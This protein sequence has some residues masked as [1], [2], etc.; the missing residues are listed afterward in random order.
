MTGFLLWGLQPVVAVRVTHQ[1][2]SVPLMTAPAAGSHGASHCCCSATAG[3]QTRRASRLIDQAA[4]ALTLEPQLQAAWRSQACRMPGVLSA[5]AARQSSNVAE[6]PVEAGTASNSTLLHNSSAALDSMHATDTDVLGAGATRD[7]GSGVGSQQAITEQQQQQSRCTAAAQGSHL[8]RSLVGECGCKL[9]CHL[10]LRLP[11][12]ED[13]TTSPFCPA[14]SARQQRF[15]PTDTVCAAVC[16]SRSDVLAAMHV[17]SMWSLNSE[18]PACSAERALRI[19]KP[20]KGGKYNQLG[21]FETHL[22]RMLDT[23]KPP[24]DEQLR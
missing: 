7:P 12:L 3:D 24:E 11:R 21:R 8:S 18:H 22:L 23:G 14:G 1:L 6:A 4:A 2:L 20:H 16:C 5:P 9:R 19:I 17:L 10:M 13:G 15:E